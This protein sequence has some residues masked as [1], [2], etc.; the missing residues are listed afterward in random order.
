MSATQRLKA[1]LTTP[2]IVTGSTNVLDFGLRAELKEAL[3]ASGKFS[4]V[5]IKF[6]SRRGH[7]NLYVRGNQTNKTASFVTAVAATKNFNIALNVV[8]SNYY[9]ATYRVT[10]LNHIRPVAG[11]VPAA[12]VAKPTAKPAAKPALTTAIAAEQGPKTKVYFGYDLVGSVS[13]S[14]AKQIRQMVEAENKPKFADVVVVDVKTSAK[15]TLTVPYDVA[16]AV[17]AQVPSFN[18]SEWTIKSTHGITILK[19]NADSTTE[20]TWIITA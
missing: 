7:L 12:P 4:D 6:D 10:K 19:Q 9:D 15:V 3:K 18:Q 11:S 2:T 1:Q 14:T 16:Q 17:K 20:K 8:T 5:S 13:A